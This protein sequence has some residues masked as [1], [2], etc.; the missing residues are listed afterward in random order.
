MM[1]TVHYV[2]MWWCMCTYCFCCAVLSSVDATNPATDNGSV[3]YETIQSK[4]TPHFYR[5]TTVIHTFNTKGQ[6]A[7]AA[8]QGESAHYIRKLGVC[9]C[10][11]FIN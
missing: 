7:A 1:A 2:F 8:A 10:V 11:Q 9:V 5:T 3:V 6:P 4:T